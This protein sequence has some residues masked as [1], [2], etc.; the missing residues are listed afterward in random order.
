MPWEPLKFILPRA[1]KNAGI[2]EQITAERVLMM[3]RNILLSRWGEERGSLISFNSFNGGVLSA[4]TPSP[5]ATQMLM[6]EKI[7]F[8]NAVNQALRKREVHSI[9]IKRKGF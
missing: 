7:D 4:E 5:A 2:T 9:Q 1:I 6:A 3:S 8:I